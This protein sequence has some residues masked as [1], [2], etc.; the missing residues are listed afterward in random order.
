MLA[1]DYWDLYRHSVFVLLTSFF[2]SL[3]QDIFLVLG[4]K[5]LKPGSTGHKFMLPSH[6]FCFYECRGEVT[7]SLT[8]WFRLPDTCFKVLKLKSIR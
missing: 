2:R 3:S 8:E 7:T 5:E 4:D 6:S 1:S